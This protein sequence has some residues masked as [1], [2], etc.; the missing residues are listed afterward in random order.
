M[1]VSGIITFIFLLLLGISTL[2]GAMGMEVMLKSAAYFI[3]FSVITIVLGVI[4]F[5][6]SLKESKILF[7][8]TSVI[9]IVFGPVAF[10]FSRKVISIDYS[11][12]RE[13]INSHDFSLAIFA[14]TILVC[15]I[16]G[17]V[18]LSISLIKNKK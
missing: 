16:M 18:N 6:S 7:L 12:H 1:K 4:T 15:L 10:L 13:L 9:C 17:I 14:I 11:I 8:I 3:V 5:I 2:I